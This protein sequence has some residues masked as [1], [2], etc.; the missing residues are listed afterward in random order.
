MKRNFRM[1]IAIMAIVCST[2]VNAQ[3]KNSG[4]K[5]TVTTGHQ[6]TYLTVESDSIGDP[7]KRISMQR[8]GRTYKIRLMNDKISSL[9]VDGATIASQDFSKYQPMVDELLEQIK[10]D[11]EQAER[12][13]QQADLDRVQADKDRQQA[14]R[15][16]EQADKDRLQAEEDRRQADKDRLQAEQDHRQADLDR[17]QADRDRVQANKDRQQEELDRAQ[18]ELD[19]KQA[20][21][22]RK[23]VEGLI[24]DLVADKL[25]DNRESVFSLELSAGGMSINDKPQSDAIFQKYKAKYLKKAGMQVNFHSDG[26]TRR[27]QVGTK[28]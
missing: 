11:Q 19:R 27:I 3:T 5:T 26:S 24:K 14:E 28:D 6:I 18:A 7:V 9:T 22:D 17:Q 20:E 15:D 1:A 25:I 4:K 21:E 2:S 23:L 16:R 13:R 8:D 12:D 10:R